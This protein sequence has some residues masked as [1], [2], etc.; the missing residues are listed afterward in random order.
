MFQYWFHILKQKID[1][2]FIKLIGFNG[3]YI[4]L[5]EFQIAVAFGAQVGII[6]NSGG[7]A[8]KLINDR[9]WQSVIPDQ[10]NNKEYATGLLVS[11]H[12]FPLF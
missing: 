6:E 7:A 9:L 12:Y 1:P 4:S 3:K 2:S 5:L 11:N 10:V 8:S